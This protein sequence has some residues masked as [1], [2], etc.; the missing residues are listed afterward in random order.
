[1]STKIR[2]DVVNKIR[3]QNDIVEVIGEYVKLTKRGKNHFG[4]CPFHGEKTPSFSVEQEKQLFHCFGC[5]KGGN[6]FTFIEEIENIPYREAIQ[7]LAKRVDYALPTT[8]ITDR[9]YSEETNQLFSAYDWLVKYY[10]HLL[11]YSEQGE[12]ALQYIRQRGLSDETIERFEI[13]FAPHDSEL[14]V[15]FLQQKG[16]Q[17]PFLVKHRLLNSTNQG[18]YLD[19][20]RGRLIFPIENHTGKRVAFGGRALGDQ[21]PKYLNSPEHTLFHKAHI[22]YNFSQARGHIRKQDEVIV[23]EGYLDVLAAYQ[24]NVR[25]VVATLGTA[26]SAEQAKLIKRTANTVIV[27]Y[28][29]DEAGLQA[30]YDAALILREHGNDVKIARLPDGQDP[31]DYIQSFGSEKFRRE[32]LDMSDSF[33]K[34]LLQYEKSKYNLTVD[35][36]RIRY[37][38]NMTK[39]LATIES[40]IEREYYINDLADEFQISAQVIT[41]DVEQERSKLNRSLKDNKPINRNTNIRMPQPNETLLPAHMRAERL[42][43]AYMMKHPQV[44][45]RVQREIGIQFTVA[46]HQVIVTHI[47]A[48]YESSNSIDVSELVDKVDDASI[49][50]IVSE[51]A[52]MNTSTQINDR[53]IDDNI[54]LIK[55]E[56]THKDHLQALKRKQKLEK[57]PILAAEIGMKIIE[58]TKQMKS[59]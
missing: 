57:N 44:I 52:I 37:I 23:F 58:L 36:E 16:F 32:I 7:F 8:Q 42:L 28:D 24:A 34:F 21:Q 48:L 12:E 53:E 4:L 43:L 10:H 47:Y 50:S 15:S 46:E 25:N 54:R 49:N 59:M 2:D 27:C 35:S 11:K 40:S 17:M 14:T 39:H 18:S 26:L 41:E 5:G 45:E 33:I 1:M 38:E 9:Q 3:E 51:L 56:F 20:F 6:V 13:G 31:D 19:P 29:G 55:S 30:S 22:L